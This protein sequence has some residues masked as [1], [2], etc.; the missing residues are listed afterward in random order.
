MVWV[1]QNT[2]VYHL[3]GDRWY[4]RTKHG[5]YACERQAEA[6]GDHRSGIRVSRQ[7]APR[8]TRR[9]SAH[10]PHTVDAQGQDARPESSVENPF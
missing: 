8:S 7:H 2:G 6:E 1:N 4:G 3:P 10:S 9:S 5:A